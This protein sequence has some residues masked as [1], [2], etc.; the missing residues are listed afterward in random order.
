MASSSV[1]FTGPVVWAL[2]AP[3]RDTTTT[4]ITNRKS[5]VRINLQPSLNDSSCGSECRERHKQRTD[6]TRRGELEQADAEQQDLQR[7]PARSA[8]NADARTREPDR[9]PLHSGV[10]WP[11][12]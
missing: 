9:A 10:P 1:I 6:I 5:C 2:A 11:D 7:S 4:E 8:R 3:A 12:A